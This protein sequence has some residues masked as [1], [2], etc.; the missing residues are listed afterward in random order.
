MQDHAFDISYRNPVLVQ[1]NSNSI[2]HMVFEFSAT[3]NESI[4]CLFLI[5]A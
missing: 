2:W 3:K 1:D 4:V 5:W